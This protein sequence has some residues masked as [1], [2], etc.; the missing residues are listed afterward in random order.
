VQQPPREQYNIMRTFIL[1]FTVSLFLLGCESSYDQTLDIYNR[2][3]QTGML[4]FLTHHTVV[5]RNG[6]YFVFVHS[7][8]CPDCQRSKQE[9]GALIRITSKHPVGV[10]MLWD[11]ST[12]DREANIF[13]NITHQTN[14]DAREIFRRHLDSVMSV[15]FTVDLWSVMCDPSQRLSEINLTPEDI[16]L[17]SVSDIIPESY[18]KEI[19]GVKQSQKIARQWYYLKRTKPLE[20]L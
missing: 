10:E 6:S 12:Q 19:G 8:N 5:E 13:L 7:D 16:L 11:D 18:V 17:F 1:S 14:A 2:F 9:A 4:K 15:F 3:I 20:P